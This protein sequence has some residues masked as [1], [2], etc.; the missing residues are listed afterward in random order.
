MHLVAHLAQGLAE[1]LEGDCETPVNG[2]SALGVFACELFAVA[3]QSEMLAQLAWR[4]G[5]ARRQGGEAG[6]EV[7]EF[8]D[9]V[10]FAYLVDCGQRRLLLSQ[11]ME[12]SGSEN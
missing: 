1:V 3:V 8:G 2:R 5:E 7:V 9:G 10:Q 4:A 12:D 11:E 6:F